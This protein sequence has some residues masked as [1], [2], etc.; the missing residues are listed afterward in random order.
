M[1]AKL[2][3]ITRW[4]AIMPIALSIGIIRRWAG[5][6]ATL[7]FAIIQYH[8]VGIQAAGFIVW[9]IL[10]YRERYEEV[11]TETETNLN[12]IYSGQEILKFDQKA[13]E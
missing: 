1:E 10:E 5:I 9:L 12:L 2:R 11:V 13:R 3:K 6:E 7:T 4:I 8:L